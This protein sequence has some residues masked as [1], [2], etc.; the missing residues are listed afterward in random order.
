MLWNKFRQGS[1]KILGGN[2]FFKGLACDVT[3]LYDFL[4]LG[5]GSTIKVSYFEETMQ[6]RSIYIPKN[7][8]SHEHWQ[9]LLDHTHNKRLKRDCQRAAFPVPIR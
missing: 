8:L 6:K 1:L 3:L 5:I 2:L 9:Q 7:A 4:P